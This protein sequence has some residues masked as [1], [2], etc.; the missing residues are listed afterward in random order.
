MNLGWNRHDVI[1]STDKADILA[2]GLGS[3]EATSIAREY[4]V[5]LKAKHA[6]MDARSSQAQKT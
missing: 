5:V 3:L 2:G 1:I 4:K 6:Q